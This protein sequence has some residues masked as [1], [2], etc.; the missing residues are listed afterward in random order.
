MKYY[1]G[2]STEDQK[3]KATQR[4]GGLSRVV[5]IDGREVI[6]RSRADGRTIEESSKKTEKKTFPALVAKV[7]DD[8]TLTINRGAIHGIS[9]GDKFLVYAI[10]PEELIDPETKESLGHLEL[11][12]GTG[13]AIHVQEKMTTIKSNRYKDGRITRRQT[14][15]LAIVSGEIIEESGKEIMPFDE[16][17]IGDMVKPM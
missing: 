15:A 7:T 9:K 4:I 1:T 16:P 3:E 13:I 2:S 5:R 6:L 14:G 11:I 8:F 17:E 10:D 12:R